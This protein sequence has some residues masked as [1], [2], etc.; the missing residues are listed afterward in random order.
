MMTPDFRVARKSV[1]RASIKINSVK[2][3]MV[4]SIKAKS[5]LGMVTKYEN[6]T[7]DALFFLKNSNVDNDGRAPLHIS[8]VDYQVS[9][10]FDFDFQ[11]R[12]I[13]HNLIKFKDAF[14]VMGGTLAALK[15]IFSIATPFII[16]HFL[17]MVS[18]AITANHARAYRDSLNSLF[19]KSL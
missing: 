15:L 14:A 6:E 5:I 2:T 10:D 1:E 16:W 19:A 3:I 4:D 7:T 12:V 18:T 13:I 8:L 11:Q 17:L 9:A